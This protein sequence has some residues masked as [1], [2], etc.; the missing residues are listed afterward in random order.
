MSG[1]SKTFRLPERGKDPLADNIRDAVGV[2][3]V[4]CVTPQF[5]RPPSEP[6][7]A[8]PPSS[9]EDWD[10]LRSMS[11]NDLREMGL[12]VWN[13]PDLEGKVLMLFPGEWYDS[14]PNGLPIEGLWSPVEE[15][16]CTCTREPELF[17]RGA[18]DDDIRFGCLPYGVRVK[19]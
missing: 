1:D 19:V 7:P 13:E 17:E 8:A 15:D 12:G 14:I 6:I 3:I 2:G 16:S 11:V 10:A 5:T 4:E 9:R 18:T